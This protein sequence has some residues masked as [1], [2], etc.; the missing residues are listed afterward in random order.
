M[1]PCRVKLFQPAGGFTVSGGWLEQACDGIVLLGTSFQV[2]VTEG[3]LQTRLTALLGGEGICWQ[4]RRGRQA[5]GGPLVSLPRRRN[6]YKRTSLIE[7]EEKCELTGGEN[8][9]AE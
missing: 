1:L 5:E 9:G 4:Y 7:V 6:F 3:V 8:C 2:D